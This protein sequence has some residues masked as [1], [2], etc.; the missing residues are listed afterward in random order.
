M[1]ASYAATGVDYFQDRLAQIGCPVLLTA[2]LTDALLPAV[3]PQ[4]CTMA[5]QIPQSCLFLV[6][7]GDHP[8]MWSRAHEFRAVADA[9]LCQYSFPP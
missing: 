9:F 7:G 5:R 8:L 4:L 1:L 2:S 3:A 6:N